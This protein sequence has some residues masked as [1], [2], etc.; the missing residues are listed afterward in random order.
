MTDYTIWVWAVAGVVPYAITYQQRRNGRR[1]RIQALFWSVER[2]T[3]PRGECQWAVCVPL[4]ERMRSVV[5]AA[6]M[7]LKGVKHHEGE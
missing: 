1:L 2:V 3:E 6:V 4:I 7:S 5:Q